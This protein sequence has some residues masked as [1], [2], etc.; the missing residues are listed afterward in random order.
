MASDVSI[1]VADATR[2]PAIRDGMHLP[3][4]G[5][6]F[7]AGNV[8]SAIES[9]RTYQPKLVAVDALF[10]QTP[11]GTAFVERIEK[12]AIADGDIRLI[13]QLEGRWVTA[14]RSSRPG[15]VSVSSP[16]VVT[17]SAPAVVAASAPAVVAARMVA[18]NTRRAPRFLVRDPLNAV[19]ENGSAG[20]VDISVLGAQ[21]VS[22]PALRPNQKI[23]IALPDTGE[24]LHAIAHVAWSTF[25][26]PRLVTDAH[27]R[28]GLEFTGT[29]QQAL[30]NYR[31]RHCAEEPIPYRGR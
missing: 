19:V 22:G 25:E 1:V 2:L 17:M 31:R 18:L 24:M 4:R 20:L 28:A 10:A 14:P 15:V 29:A 6:H 7:T 8:A 21:V 3:G 13:V 5:M 11:P 30:E 27:Y 16:A 26:R 12:L 23:K 9:I